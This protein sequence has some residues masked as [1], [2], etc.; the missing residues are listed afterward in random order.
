MFRF[1]ALRPRFRFRPRFR[2][3]LFA[4][5]AWSLGDLAVSRFSHPSLPVFRAH[6][7]LM[8]MITG[9]GVADP[10]VGRPGQSARLGEVGLV[11]SGCPG[12]CARFVT[13]FVFRFGAF[14]DG[15]GVH[16]LTDWSA[17]LS[18][19]ENA[20]VF[21]DQ[22]F[23]APKVVSVLLQSQ[24]RRSDV[25]ALRS[26]ERAFLQPAFSTFPI[27]PGLLHSSNRFRSLWAL[28]PRK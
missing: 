12:D 13:G 1:S 28:L 24:V 27:V 22:G 4:V 25:A 8:S 3:S 19:L 23:P 9:F 2:S 16:P 11:P 6:R 26:C 15:S 10:A 7:A 21:C 14:T 17:H 18:C 20:V 5:P